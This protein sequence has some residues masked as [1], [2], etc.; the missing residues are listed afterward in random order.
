MDLLSQR[1]ANPCF[2]LDGVIQTGGFRQFV[3]NLIRKR[4]EERA[5][6]IEWDVYLHKVFNQSFADY[7]AEIE[8]NK[9]NREMSERTIETTVIHSMNILN[10]FN[11][12][13][14]ERGEIKDNGTI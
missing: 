13:Q 1:Y 12:N 5:E 11:P 8:N 4:N 3:V 7:K 2:F 6:Q 10:N 14:E 9:R